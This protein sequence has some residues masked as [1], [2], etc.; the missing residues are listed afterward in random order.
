MHKRLYVR[1]LPNNFFTSI[2]KTNHQWNIQMPLSALSEVYTHSIR[3]HWSPKQKRDN[4][5]S[6]NKDVFYQYF[7]AF[8]VNKNN[9]YDNSQSTCCAHTVEV[10]STNRK[11]NES[12]IP[13]QILLSRSSR[14]FNALHLYS[15]LWYIVRNLAAKRLAAPM[16][17]DT[18]VFP[19]LIKTQEGIQ[20]WELIEKRLIFA[21][22][23]RISPNWWLIKNFW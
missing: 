12:K 21:E 15:P 18:T 11:G 14:W 5:K 13:Q 17:L 20:F 8:L 22:G 16:A 3:I 2:F 23:S 6:H 1:I 4:R 19:H 9:K 10:P 7:M